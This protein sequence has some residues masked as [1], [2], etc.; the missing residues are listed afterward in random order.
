[1]RILVLLAK[2]AITFGLLA[3]L[4][5]KID[6]EAALAQARQSDSLTLIAGT[7]LL[8]LL[9]VLGSIRWRTIM[10]CLGAPAGFGAVTRWT[11][12]AVFLGQILPA[13]VGRDAFRA[14][15][16]YRGGCGARAAVN[17]VGLDRVVMTLSLAILFAAVALGLL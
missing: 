16:A 14:W 4:Y 9:P 17:S 8:G 2:F 11:Y 12:V 1:M 10:R 5:F 15:L 6:P 7:L 3:Y 13:T